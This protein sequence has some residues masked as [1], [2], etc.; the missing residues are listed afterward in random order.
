M[1]ETEDGPQHRVNLTLAFYL[2]IYP[3]TQAHWQAVMG[4]NPSRFAGDDRP[5]EQVCWDDCQE[6]C[7]K[8]SRL[9]GR[10]F[11]LPTEAEWEYA[12]RA[13]TTTP[14]YFGDTLTTGQGN[15]NSQWPT[16]GPWPPHQGVY[17]TQTTPVGKFPPNAWGL[18][19]MH[20]NVW[21]WCRDKKRPYSPNQ[22]EVTDPVYSQGVRRAVRGGSWTNQPVLCRSAC[23]CAGAPGA[24]LD[25]LGFRVAMCIES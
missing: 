13:G 9:T 2:G 4:N 24:R 18:Y 5:V 19:D 12:C 17:R 14:F 23:R 11:R 3:V 21:E 15:F 22:E 8:I 7:R 6:F 20:G 10:T 16:N 25:I 1:R